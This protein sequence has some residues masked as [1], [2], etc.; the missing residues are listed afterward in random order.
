MS[1]RDPDRDAGSRAEGG[2]PG[3]AG[4]TGDH[5]ADEKL[6]THFREASGAAFRRVGWFVAIGAGLI[7]ALFES[8]MNGGAR[9]ALVAAA[10]VAW[11][12]ALSFLACRGWLPI[13]EES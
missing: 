8:A 5:A 1:P 12:Y 10:C 13:M 6:R 7:A 4:R 9:F 11:G 3:R 2:K